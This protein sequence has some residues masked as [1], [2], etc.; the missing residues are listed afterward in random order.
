MQIIPNTIIRILADVPLDNTYNHSIYFSN[1]AD[2][3]AY[4]MRKTR[5]LLTAQSYQRVNKG[6]LRVQVVADRIYDCNY[7]MFQ[8]SS[9]GSKWFY[10]FITKVEYINNST[11]EIEYQID[12]LMTW[13]GEARLP[14]RCYVERQHS[15]TDEIGDNI[16]PE[17]IACG[18][19]VFA[20]SGS[21]Y[22]PMIDTLANGQY[23]ACVLAAPQIS[24]SGGFLT[25]TVGEPEIVNNIDSIPTG[26]RI[27]VKQIEN[28]YEGSVAVSEIIN[29]LYKEKYDVISLY[30]T[31]W[32]FF[33]NITLSSDFLGLPSIPYRYSTPTRSFRG[34]AL[35][36]GMPLDDYIPKNAKCYTYPYTYLSIDNGLGQSGTFRYEMFDNKMPSF[37]IDASVLQPVQLICR[38]TGY[39]GAELNFHEAVTL[40][41]FPTGSWS[42]DSYAVYL[43][44]HGG[45]ISLGNGAGSLGL[46]VGDL[47]NIGSNAAKGSGMGIAGIA[48]NGLTSALGAISS[49]YAS[50]LQL[51]TV[52]GNIA[53]G[54]PNIANN[55]Q[56]LYA[57]TMCV[58]SRDMERIDNFFEVYGYAHNT[59]TTPNI[60]SRPYWNYI[61]TAGV[62]LTGTVPAEDMRALEAIYNSG[63]TFWK[64]GD[65]V[66][67]YTLNNH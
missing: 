4:F 1:V 25:T 67:N 39:K 6:S 31:P 12:P 66:G 51:D 47:V 62:T 16:T 57:G 23:A 29:K 65:I 43:A 46:A 42:A 49:N 3:T 53:S 26:G 37:R 27:F 48:A 2:Q 8:N 61:K 52:R 64:N 60:S 19:Y 24:T 21:T 17:G 35:T 14:S 59:L 30:I 38:P 55:Q 5:Q 20:G 32:Y 28:D 58:N 22:G 50:S 9:Y 36:K 56:N 54:S 18:E 34:P 13:W 44:N 10:A 41:G 11:S 40:G 7:L 33:E 63:I 45:E 15:I